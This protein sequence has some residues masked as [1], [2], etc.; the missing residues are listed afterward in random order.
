MPGS[1]PPV[2]QLAADSQNIDTCNLDPAPNPAFDLLGHPRVVDDP[3]VADLA[4]PLDRGAVE[5]SPPIFSD[6]FED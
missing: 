4:G 2:L 3:A 5:H 6:G 1:P